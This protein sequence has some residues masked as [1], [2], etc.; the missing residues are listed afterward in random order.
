MMRIHLVLAKSIWWIVL[1]GGIESLMSWSEEEE[2]TEP[3]VM[4]RRNGPAMRPFEAA[5]YQVSRARESCD[6]W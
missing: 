3:S 4:M 5:A 6:M 2:R 1:M